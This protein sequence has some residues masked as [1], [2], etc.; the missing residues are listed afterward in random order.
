VNVVYAKTY[1]I[2]SLELSRKLELHAYVFEF[3]NVAIAAPDHIIE[4]IKGRVRLFY[5]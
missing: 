4:C 5:H 1:A 2:E 3:K